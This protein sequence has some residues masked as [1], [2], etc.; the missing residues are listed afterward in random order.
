MGWQDRQF[1]ERFRGGD[2]G[3]IGRWFRRVFGDGENPLTWAVTL[4]RAWGITVKIHLIYMIWIIAKLIASGARDQF[5]FVL[6]VMTMAALFGL[7]LIHEYG[8]CF[9]CRRVGGE[10]DQILMWP[11]G[12]L[13]YCSPPHSWRAHLATVVGGP[14]V[15]VVLWPILGAAVWGLTG[16]IGDI[17]FN[18]FTPG[19]VLGGLTLRSG[20]ASYA[21]AGVWLLYYLNV[22]LLAFNVLLPMYP[23]DGGRILQALLWAKIGYQR[24]MAISTTLGLVAAVVLSV[25][26]IVF[27][28]MTLFAIALFA[29]ITCWMQQ[30]QLRFVGDPALGGYD[31]DRGFAGMPEANEEPRTPSRRERRRAQKQADYEK[32]FDRILDKISREGMGGLTAREKHVLSRDTARRRGR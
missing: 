9:A 5:G 32:E 31:F 8:H 14:M 7:V 13:A 11:L 6:T 20:G 29:G 23:M 10:A 27:G 12:G 17:V 4:Y 26:A 2:A 22:V 30:R 21:L 3:G 18:P 16:S 25:M 19:S 1:D 15:N 28:Q 24:S